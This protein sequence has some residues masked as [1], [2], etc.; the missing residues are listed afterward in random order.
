MRPMASAAPI[1]LPEAQHRCALPVSPLLGLL[2]RIKATDCSS[3]RFFSTAGAGGIFVGTGVVD[4]PGKTFGRSGTGSPAGPE[5]LM[6]ISTAT[7][8]PEEARSCVRC[9]TP[10]HRPAPLATTTRLRFSVSTPDRPVQS[11]VPC[12][13]KSAPLPFLPGHAVSASELICSGD[14]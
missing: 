2:I 11:Q 8:I 14:M 10:A 9:G 12:R 13:W 7:S 4:M 3:P 1:I 6:V 5:R